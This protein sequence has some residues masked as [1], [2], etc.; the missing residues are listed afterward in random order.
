M[1]LPS[2]NFGLRLRRTL[3]TLVFLF[4][5]KPIL[6]ASSKTLKLNPRR[7]NHDMPRK[8][9]QLT[10]LDRGQCEALVA[11]LSGEFVLIQGPPGTRKSYLGFRSCVS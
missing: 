11:A 4:E 3:P 7:E 6:N 10:S 5:L 9:E 8:L 1:C 2:H